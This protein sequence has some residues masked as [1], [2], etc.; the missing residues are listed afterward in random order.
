[1]RL[2]FKHT[3][4]NRV[5]AVL[6]RRLSREPAGSRL[7]AAAIPV[8]AEWDEA[9]LRVESY[10]RAHRIESRVQ[11]NQLTTDIINAARV[12]AAKHPDEPPVT[13]AL[14]ITHAR[15]GEW[16]VHA[17]GQGDWAD[18]RF[19][20]RGR[21]AILLADIPG[22]CP[23]RFLAHDEIPGDLKTQLSQARLQPGPDVR[24]TRMPSTPLEFPLAGMVG[25]KWETFS[26]SIFV[27]AATS[28]LLIAGFL[29]FAWFATH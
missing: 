27:R 5:Q 7:P 4:A 9:F 20:A 12:I 13:V 16:L 3:W 19:R 1:M 28:W 29:G 25:E 24:L 17:V 23:E 18:E 2:P 26:R 14:Q 22:R 21:L 8:T 11:L 15:I 6:R 10:L